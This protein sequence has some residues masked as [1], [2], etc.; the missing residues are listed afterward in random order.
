MFRITVVEGISKFSLISKDS[1]SVFWRYNDISGQFETYMRPGSASAPWRNAVA[2]A[3]GLANMNST[4]SVF[5][6][7]LHKDMVEFKAY[8]I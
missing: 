6:Y 5:I 7:P 2:A 8:V 1:A 4:S 3:V